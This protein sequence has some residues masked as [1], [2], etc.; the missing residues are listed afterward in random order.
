LA[1][2]THLPYPDESFDIAFNGVSLMHI[3]DYA[4][5]IREAARVAA[6]TCIFHSVPVFADHPTTFLQ[7]Y[8]YGAPVVEVVFAEAELLSLCREAG[9]RLVREWPSIPYDVFAVTGHRSVAKTY[10]FAAG[11]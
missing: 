1:D 10:L 6:R 11:G 7:K 3:I 2:A 8:A 9:L 4:A 5:A